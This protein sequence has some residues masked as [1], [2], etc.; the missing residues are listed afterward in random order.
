MRQPLLFGDGFVF[1]RAGNCL[2]IEAKITAI[3]AIITPIFFDISKI[4]A[5]ITAIA[6]IYAVIRK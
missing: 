3:A 2:K 5:K 6:A 4:Q 1:A